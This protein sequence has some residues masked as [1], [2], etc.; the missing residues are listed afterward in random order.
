MGTEPDASCRAGQGTGLN[1]RRAPW[2]IL[3]PST[4]RSGGKREESDRRPW[5]SSTG[6]DMM[7]CNKQDQETTVK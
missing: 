3:E 6:N 2:K 4:D 7:L 1:I 5:I